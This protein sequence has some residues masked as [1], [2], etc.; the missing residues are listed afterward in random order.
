MSFLTP[1]RKYTHHFFMRWRAVKAIAPIRAV[2][3]LLEAEAVKNRVQL[4][5]VNGHRLGRMDLMCDQD[6]Y[7]HEEHDHHGHE[8]MSFVA[9]LQITPT[10]PRSFSQSHAGTTL[11]AHEPM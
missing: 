6:P 11:P 7:Q 8:E 5:L 9:P 10:G 4:E 2:N 1:Q 3:T